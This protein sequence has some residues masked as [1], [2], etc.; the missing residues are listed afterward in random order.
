MVKAPGIRIIDGKRI[1]LTELRKRRK[2]AK[3]LAGPVEDSRVSDAW[4]RSDAKERSRVLDIAE[5]KSISSLAPKA[6]IKSAT[7]DNPDFSRD[8]V[9]DKYGNYRTI[10]ANINVKE[11]AISVLA[12]RGALDAAQVA[13]ADRFRKLW[14][15]LGGAGAGAMDYTKEPVDGGGSVDPIS[16]RQL[17]AGMELK[18]ASDALQAKYG[19]YAYKLVGYVAGEGHNLTELTETRRQRD[20]MTDN[21]RMYLDL[22]AE[23]WGYRNSAQRS[24][25]VVRK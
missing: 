21:L 20:T 1:D 14:E 6:D 2:L 24:P 9:E 19:I 7:I 23:L 3:E 25:R 18:T 13:A 22:L 17:A 8:H 10:Q 5:G 12:A 11:G 15:Q 4:A 16:L